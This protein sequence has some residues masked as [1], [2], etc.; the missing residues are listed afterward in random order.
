[1]L[2]TLLRN[3]FGRQR[4]D[5]TPRC[6]ECGNKS[7]DNHHVVPRRVGGTATV[8]LCIDCHRKAHN[9]TEEEA[10][11]KRLRAGVTTL[12]HE[13]G[14]PASVAGQILGIPGRTARRIAQKT[15]K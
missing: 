14:F 13:Y 12:V 9:E 1:M 4:G 7:H 6:F 2:R 5:N 10:L 11:R 15:R 8:P 3:L